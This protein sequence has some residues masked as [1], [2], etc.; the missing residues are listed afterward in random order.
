MTKFETSLLA[1]CQQ[2]GFY[3]KTIGSVP[4][5]FTYN[6]PLWL[7][8]TMEESLPTIPKALI[9]SGFHGEEQA[10]PWGILKWLRD[11]TPESFK[12]VNVSFLP[13]VNLYGFITEKRYGPSNMPTNTGFYRPGEKASPEAEIL[14]KNINILR[15]LAD[16]GYISLHEDITSSQYYIYTFEPTEQPGEFSKQMKDELAKHF[17]N[18]FNGIAYVDT[19]SPGQGPPCEDGLIWKFYDGS[20]DDWMFQMG[21]PRVAVT[22]TPGKYPFLDRVDATVDLINRFIDLVSKGV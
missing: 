3:P 14:K 16:N 9:V 10:G 20:F 5:A 21:V 12:G 22:E 4:G 6:Y 18:P 15:P 7:I 17:P 11:C 13:V 1:I 19:T 8:Q 2:K